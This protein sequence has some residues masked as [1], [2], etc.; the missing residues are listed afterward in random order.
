MSSA[1]SLAN[2]HD[3]EIVASGGLTPGDGNDLIELWK[4]LR[5]TSADVAQCGATS[6]WDWADSCIYVG[7]I[8]KL[9]R[10]SGDK[11]PD[12]LPL[13][14]SN[15]LP[16]R[17]VGRPWGRVDNT[18]SAPTVPNDLQDDDREGQTHEDLAFVSEEFQRRVRD[19]PVEVPELGPLRKYAPLVL[20]RQDGERL[21]HV[22]LHD[23]F[24][25]FAREHGTLNRI[26]PNV[27]NATPIS[28]EGL[29]HLVDILSL[30][31]KFADVGGRQ[32]FAAEFS[33]RLADHSVQA[34]TLVLPTG[35][36]FVSWTAAL[37]KCINL[38]GG[39]GAYRIPTETPPELLVDALAACGDWRS[40]PLPLDRLGALR[41]YA[42]AR[43]ESGSKTAGC[44]VYLFDTRL[45]FLIKLP[46]GH[47]HLKHSIMLNDIVSVWDASY[48]GT[49]AVCI[50]MHDEVP[51]PSRSDYVFQLDN[52]EE[53]QEWVL[54]LTDLARIYSI[55]YRPRAA[56]LDMQDERLAHY[57]SSNSKATKSSW[58]LAGL[59]F[60]A[61]STDGGENEYNIG[62][63][64]LPQYEGD[65]L[66]TYA[67]AQTLNMAFTTLG[68]H[69]VQAR[70]LHPS[71][72][73]QSSSAQAV[74]KAVSKFVH[75]GFA[76]EGTRRRAVMHPI[77][78]GW[79]DVSV[80]ALL[81]LDWTIRDSIKPPKQTLW[82]EMFTRHQRERESLLRWE[83]GGL[84]RTRS[85]ETVRK[86]QVDPAPTKSMVGDL[87][88]TDASSSVADPTPAA[89]PSVLAA[90]DAPPPTVASARSVVTGTSASSWAAIVD[91]DSVEPVSDQVR[92]W[93]E[94]QVAAAPETPDE[95]ND[96]E[97]TF[98]SDWDD[99]VDDVLEGAD[100]D[101]DSE[102]SEN[103][104]SEAKHAG[105]A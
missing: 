83:G 16:R 8:R 14:P 18:W 84:K 61:P 67:M 30:R 98:S 4:S 60:L 68:A 52:P 97:S 81:D 56:E 64:L 58:Y 11:D 25:I 38:A 49:S 26:E 48:L 39:I 54:E 2:R 34:M 80:L 88:F 96:L 12:P 89:A 46:T 55:K 23:T 35:H 69:R 53:A 72:T 94:Q 87:D 105:P 19:S 24:L 20:Q 37:R 29:V 42:A 100:T 73:G 102:L 101:E 28:V 47:V 85:M 79:A 65:G 59:T 3:V 10:P 6:A 15:D 77:E 36:D 43:I 5:A 93:M 63:A 74:A 21:Y 31:Y 41:R 92:R 104:D 62:I 71:T 17:T 95:A 51:V 13:W 78:N 50:T 22:F 86:L 99:V 9:V 40:F 90:S 76:L 57:T 44:G 33:V 82:D 75:W 66:G 70:I 103:E 1:L 7:A 32:T 91:S 45:V 27:Y